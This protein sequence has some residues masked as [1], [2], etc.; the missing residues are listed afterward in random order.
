[1]E[2]LSRAISQRPGQAAWHE[3]RAQMKSELGDH[4]GA[5]SDYDAILAMHAESWNLRRGRRTLT[6]A[7][8][9]QARGE[10]RFRAGRIALSL[11]DFD[12]FLKSHPER[13][14]HHW[15]RG[16]ALYYAGRHAEAAKQFESHRA[17]NPNDVENAAWHFLCVARDRGIAAARASL[18][19]TRGDARVP[20]AEIQQLFA[21]RASPD[22][23]LAACKAGDPAPAELNDRLFFAHL[24]LALHHEA[25]SRPEDSLKSIK[26]AVEE[27]PSSS[28]MGDVARVHLALRRP[29]PPQAESKP[30]AKPQAKPEA[31]R[32]PQP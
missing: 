11:E 29:P 27:Y 32:T 10:A 16:I 13:A 22:D 28:Y 23:V 7:D 8:L 6:A 20:M 12:A 3:L 30:E 5:A 26:L 9:R 15:Q 4:A 19:P 14:P 17:V 25:H 24:Y 21:D 1:M 2:H 18:I 31:A